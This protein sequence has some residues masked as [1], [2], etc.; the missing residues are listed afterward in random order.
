[1]VVFSSSLMENYLQYGINLFFYAKEA[2]QHA[3][4]NIFTKHLFS[5][6]PNTP[7]GNVP[8]H[9]QPIVLRLPHRTNNLVLVPSTFFRWRRDDSPAEPGSRHQPLLLLRGIPLEHPLSLCWTLLG[10]AL[11][12]SSRTTEETGSPQPPPQAHYS[13]RH[14]QASR[15]RRIQP[16]RTS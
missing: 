5:Q 11:A 8:Y 10:P 4:N 6:K 14:W 3:N 2:K 12:P 1:M 13:P 7:Y 16:L 15:L 9:I